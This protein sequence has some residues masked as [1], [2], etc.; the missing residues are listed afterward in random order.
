MLEVLPYGNSLTGVDKTA[1]HAME[2]TKWRNKTRLGN[3]LRLYHMYFARNWRTGT[4]FCWKVQTFGNLISQNSLLWPT[5]TAAMH[6]VC[7]LMA[8][9]AWVMELP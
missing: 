9:M 8:L 6:W 5:V 3:N 7:D 2:H 1:R 4:V